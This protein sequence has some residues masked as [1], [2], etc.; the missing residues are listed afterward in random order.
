MPRTYVKQK[1]G[2]RKYQTYSEEI[3]HKCL[4]AVESGKLSERKAA[5]E[6]KVPR[7]TIQNYLMCDWGF[8]INFQDLKILISSY[9]NKQRRGEPR[10][11]NNVPGDDWI[12][13]FIKRRKLTHRC[14]SNIKRKR[15][16][17][18]KDALKRYFTNL[19]EELKDVPPINIWNYDETNLT[20]DPGKKKAIMRRGTKYPEQVINHSKVGFSIMFCGN[21]AGQMLEPY[22]VY[23]AKNMYPAWMEGGPP[24]ARYGYSDS[25]WFEERSLQDWFFTLA[26]PKLWRLDGKKVLIG[27]NLNSHLSDKVIEAC[28]ANNIAFICL[29][30]NGTHLLQPLDIAYFAPLKKTWRKVL[31]QWKLTPEGRRQGTLNKRQYPCLLSKLIESLASQNGLE[32]LKSGFRKCGIVPFQPEEVYKRLPDSSTNVLA[33]NEA[34]GDS[35]SDTLKELRGPGPGNGET[36]SGSTTKKKSNKVSKKD[37]LHLSPGK[38]VSLKEIPSS[39][40]SSQP[41]APPG[42][43]TPTKGLKVAGSK[44]K[45]KRLSKNKNNKNIILNSAEIIPKDHKAADYVIVDYEGSKF[46]GQIISVAVRDGKK[47]YKVSCLQKNDDGK[48]WKWPDIADDD[49]Y[50]K[51]ESEIEKPKIISSRGTGRFQIPEFVADWGE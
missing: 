50:L 40:S 8:P 44:L 25:G 19:E 6:F 37:R 20:D 38:S 30:P 35:L 10:F 24:N 29:Y 31:N 26:L 4:D 11:Q 14:A 32:N 45:V 7:G 17:I 33:P 5:E 3:L 16:E 12:R 47:V 13:A 15:A 22:T 18:S 23:Q 43:V 36:P 42:S 46:P 41:P 39:S 1:P 49:D 9:L 2:K 34:L 48:G 27:D 51:I 28:Q 21:A